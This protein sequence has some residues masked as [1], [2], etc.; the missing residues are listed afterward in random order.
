MF[1]LFV[2]DLVLC[3]PGLPFSV[4]LSNILPA[5]LLSVFR[6]SPSVSVSISQSQRRLQACL[7]APFFFLPYAFSSTSSLALL[8]SSGVTCS[9][10]LTVPDLDAV[11]GSEGSS[12]SPLPGR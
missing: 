10:L 11:P 7:L 9:P 4:S 1:V 6:P 12:E 2:M 3:T 5:I 8:H